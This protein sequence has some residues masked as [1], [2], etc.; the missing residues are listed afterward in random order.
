MQL[1]FQHFPWPSVCFVNHRGSLIL[2]HCHTISQVCTD[3]ATPHLTCRVFCTGSGSRTG[4][5]GHLC[6]QAPV[7]TAACSGAQQL[8]SP[9]TDILGAPAQ[10][11]LGRKAYVLSV[12]EHQHSPGGG[13]NTLEVMV[14]IKAEKW[15]HKINKDEMMEKVEMIWDITYEQGKWAYS[16]SKV[17]MVNL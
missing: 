13:N 2:H 1:H 6:Y 9:L 3:S 14:E 12:L 16:I 17:D 8:Q 4:E 10:P 5:A 11:T 15:K 7:S